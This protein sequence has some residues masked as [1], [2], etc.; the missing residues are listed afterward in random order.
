MNKWSLAAILGCAAITA[1]TAAGSFKRFEMEGNARI[2]YEQY[3]APC[4]SNVSVT[5][6][7]NKPFSVGADAVY[8]QAFNLIKLVQKPDSVDIGLLR[9]LANVMADGAEQTVSREKAEKDLE[10]FVS[11]D[12]FVGKLL[13][14]YS[15]PSA[16]PVPTYEQRAHFDLLCY[17]HRRWSGVINELIDVDNDWKASDVEL[18]K[19][20]YK[21]LQ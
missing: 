15:G 2:S 10:F 3:D 14:P 17:Q 20:I 21:V 6:Q 19:A 13:R 11:E 1:A 5:N 12:S 9:E 16:V 7:Y 8:K 4:N 18:Y